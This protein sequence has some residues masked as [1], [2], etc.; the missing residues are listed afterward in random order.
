MYYSIYKT[1]SS[2]CSA[3]Y[4]MLR[5]RTATAMLF[6]SSVHESDEDE[7]RRQSK[8]YYVDQCRKSLGYNPD[9]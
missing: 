8:I 6:L 9:V 7:I 4:F 1:I 2:L 5:D 3:Y